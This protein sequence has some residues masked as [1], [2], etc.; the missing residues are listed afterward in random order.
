MTR[1]RVGGEDALHYRPPPRVDVALLRG[2]VADPDGNIGFGREALLGD[3]LNQVGRRGGGEARAGRRARSTDAPP[4]P[5]QAIAAH[6]TG[7]GRVRVIVQVGSLVARGALPPRDVAVPGALVDAVVVVGD[8]SPWQSQ[9]V[10]GGGWDAALVS[11]AAGGAPARAPLAGL[12]RVVAH[13]AMLTIT[14]H[15]LVNVGVGMPEARERGRGE[16][17]RAADAPHPPP[18]TTTFFF[19]F[20]FLFNPAPPPGRGRHGGRARRP[21][22]P[23]RVHPAHDG[24]GVDRGHARGRPRVWRGVPPPGPSAHRDH[25]RLLQWGRDRR[26]VFGGEGRVGRAARGARARPRPRPPTRTAAP[27]AAPPAATSS[28]VAGAGGPAS[29]RAAVAPRAAP[30]ARA[31]CAPP[32]ALERPARRPARSSARPHTPPPPTPPTPGRRPGGPQRRRQRLLLPRAGAGVRRVHRHQFVRQ[33]GRVRLLLHVGR[34]RGVRAR[35]Q[36]HH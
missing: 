15:A 22:H 27:A 25:A 7:R 6:N 2:S 10:G 18:P 28:A 35:R 17:G 20:F 34:P 12:R 23:R 31:P 3:A 11:A 33:G 16:R 4:P 5:P 8:D 32:R 13:R 30:R 1:V 21:R 9:V 19:S 26:R 29:R 24:S 36:A 14:Q